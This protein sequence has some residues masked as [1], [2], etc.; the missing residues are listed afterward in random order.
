MLQNTKIGSSTDGIVKL[1]NLLL[2]VPCSA[3][4]ISLVVAVAQIQLVACLFTALNLKFREI[5]H[6]RNHLNKHNAHNQ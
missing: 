1:V 4:L 3:R 5:F 6:L 2:N